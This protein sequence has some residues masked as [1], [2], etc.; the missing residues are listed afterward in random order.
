MSFSTVVLAFLASSGAW[1][2][3][4]AP[5][6]TD[7]DR[8]A[9]DRVARMDADSP[10]ARLV[11]QLEALKLSEGGLFLL[12]GV[13]PVL[14]DQVIN[15]KTRMVLEYLATLSGT[16]LSELRAGETVVRTTAIWKKHEKEKLL[17]I[18]DAW[19]IKKHKKLKYMRIG[20]LSGRSMRFELVGKKDEMVVELALG[21]LPVRQEKAL[22]RLTSH[23]GAQPSPIT[24]G[25][26]SRLPLVD[27]SFEKEGVL[28]AAWKTSKAIELGNALPANDISLDRNEVLDGNASLRMNSDTNTRH[29]DMV[30]QVVPVTGGTSLVLRGN[31]KVKR[32][33]RERDQD[34]RFFMGMQFL[35]AAGM[36]VGERM[37]NIE[38]GDMDWRDQAL[39]ATAPDNAVA[40]RISLVCT[41]SGTVWFDGLTLEVGY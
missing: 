19:D 1:A 24:S 41:M 31:V 16:T 2:T 20:D 38:S 10:P 30:E 13:E 6:P 21:D 28:N 27:G 5:V 18:A 9:A 17:D 39:H 32:V 12:G 26:G 36:V 4:N 14:V 15:E 33:V 29:W 23:F 7:E 34:R 11:M 22:K 3:A 35:D 25:P 40:V 37:A 8:A